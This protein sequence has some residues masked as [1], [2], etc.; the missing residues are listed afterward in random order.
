MT[1]YLCF[2]FSHQHNTIFWYCKTRV[3]CIKFDF[4]EKK[5]CHVGK[6]AVPFLPCNVRIISNSNLCTFPHFT[7]T[8]NIMLLFGFWFL[9][10]YFSDRCGERFSMKSSS[11]LFPI[12]NKKKKTSIAFQILYL[13]IEMLCSSQ[14]PNFISGIFSKYDLCLNLF[15]YQFDTVYLWKSKY[16]RDC[17][18][19]KQIL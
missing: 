9:G 14:H 2:A 1:I 15:S 10:G 16:F 19:L 6:R 11:S 8:H 7:C 3:I 17:L 13:K 18:N 12:F 5:N 4:C